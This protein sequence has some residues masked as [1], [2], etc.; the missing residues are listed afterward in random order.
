VRRL[1]TIY[2][3]RGFLEQTMESPVNEINALHYARERMLEVVE[4]QTPAGEGFHQ[5]ITVVR[6]HP[7]GSQRISGT[8]FGTDSSRIVYLDRYLTD[9][10]PEGHMVI[11]SNDD[12]P[13][14]VGLVGTILGDAGLN[15]A[16]M[17]VGRDTSGGTA[18]AIFNLDSAVAD[19]TL[20]ALRAVPGI[21]W[22]RHLHV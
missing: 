10:V 22:V 20:E 7:E 8:L 15:I 17:T 21:L 11:L 18:L 1:I 12:R 3:L 14:I 16:Y 4:E 5:L 2:T 19:N 13:G 6:N 9:A